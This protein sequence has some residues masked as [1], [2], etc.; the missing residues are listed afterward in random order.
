MTRCDRTIIAILFEKHKEGIRPA[1][2]LLW[3]WNSHSKLHD[4]VCVSFYGSV[5]IIV[6]E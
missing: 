3:S 2:V 5:V 6:Y 1:A 4:Y